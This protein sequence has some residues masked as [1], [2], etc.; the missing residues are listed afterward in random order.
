MGLAATYTA[1]PMPPKTDGQNRNPEDVTHIEA[2]DGDRPTW[3][4]AR[5]AVV[6]AKANWL[7][8]VMVGAT[9]DLHGRR[10]KMSALEWGVD[11]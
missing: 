5:H 11:Y 9:N 2:A 8:S 1:H 4:T 7:P 6:I 3:R 10:R